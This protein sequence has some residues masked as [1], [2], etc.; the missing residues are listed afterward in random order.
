MPVG[1]DVHSTFKSLGTGDCYGRRP[2]FAAERTEHHVVTFAVARIPRD[3]YRAV[4]AYGDRGM[5]IAQRRRADGDRRFHA[6]GRHTA[7]L[8]IELTAD[9]A[10]PNVAERCQSIFVKDT[11][12]SKERAI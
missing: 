8:D 1:R 12:T 11:K 9:I 5:P 4:A 7:G 2:L 3:V 10:L 6:V